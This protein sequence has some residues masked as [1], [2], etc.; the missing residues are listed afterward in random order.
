[1]NFQGWSRRRFLVTGLALIL[2]VV[3]VVGSWTFV[4][5]WEAGM[6]PWQPEPTRVVVTPFANLPTPDATP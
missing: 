5:A 2:V 6:L 4:D 1:M 3:I